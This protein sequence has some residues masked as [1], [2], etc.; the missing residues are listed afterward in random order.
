MRIKRL[1]VLTGVMALCGALWASPAAADEHLPTITFDPP[2]VP[3]ETGDVTVTASGANW[4]EP[5][6]FFITSCTGAGGDPTAPLT[7]SSAADAIAM[8]PNLMASAISVEWDSGF[9]PPSGPLR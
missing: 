5:T 8:C 2:S 7:L 9:S 3:A 4:P 1:F 6:P